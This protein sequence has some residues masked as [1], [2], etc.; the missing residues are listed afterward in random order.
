MEENLDEIAEGTKD[1]QPIIA[2]FYHPFHDL[3]EKKNDELSK[4]DTLKMRELGTD[5]K[6]GKPIYARIGRFGAFV[7][8]GSKEDEEKP[9]FASLQKGQSVETITFEQAL[10]LLTL[11]RTLGQDEDGFDIKANIGRFGPYVQVEKKYYSIKDQDPYT[12]TLEQAL[13][14]IREGKEKQANK[15][16]KI[17]LVLI[18]R[19]SMVAMA[20]IS[21]MARKTPKYPK[22]KLQK[23]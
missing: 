17:F 5:P 21:L 14:I 8:L 18:S 1:W 4:Q 10:V 6:T 12:I 13:E 22:I 16:V 19:S 2:T 11:P 9:R 7:Q 15:E 20:S 3:I 23:N